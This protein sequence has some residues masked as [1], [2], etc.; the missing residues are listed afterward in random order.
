MNLLQASLGGSAAFR[1]PD[2]ILENLTYA[3]AS[4]GVP[5]LPYTIA[6][7]L[8]HISATMR[9][10]LNLASGRASDWP[11]GLEVWP[12]TPPSTEEYAGI[13]LDIGLALAEAVMLAEDPSERAREVLTD[14]AVHNAYHWGQVALLRRLQ[15][16]WSGE[17]PVIGG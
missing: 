4:T 17:D 9:A 6:D 3:G 8:Y 11:E 10:S 15:G 16:D 7:V 5:G 1:E 12:D 13:R 14:L 2:Y